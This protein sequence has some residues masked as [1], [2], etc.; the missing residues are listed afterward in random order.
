MTYD[1]RHWQGVAG[2]GREDVHSICTTVISRTSD[3]GLVQCYGT[4]LGAYGRIV[5]DAEGAGLVPPEFGEFVLVIEE[6]STLCFA[7]GAYRACP[8]LD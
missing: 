4:L 5:S 1:H 6:G 2:T 7:G 8:V 3:D